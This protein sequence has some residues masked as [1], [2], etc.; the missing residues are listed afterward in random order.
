MKKLTGN[1]IRNM[2]LDFFKNKG[3][4]VEKGASLIPYNDPTLLW[5]NSGVAALK[6]YMDGSEVPPSRRITNVQKSIRTNDMDNVG[7]TSRHHTFFEM[8]GRTPNIYFIRCS[9]LLLFP[10]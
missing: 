1:E 6:K 5:I 3:H 9:T 7:Y 2:W 4:H 8:L 10:T